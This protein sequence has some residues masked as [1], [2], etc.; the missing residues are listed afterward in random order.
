MNMNNGHYLIIPKVP[1]PVRIQE[2]KGHG[3]IVEGSSGWR[4]LEI[5]L[6]KKFLKFYL[7]I[8]AQV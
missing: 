7:L 8:S 6:S 3:S 1:K 4:K 2:I 5:V